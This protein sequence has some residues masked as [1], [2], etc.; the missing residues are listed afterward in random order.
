MKSNKNR[1]QEH[2]EKELNKD[3]ENR[4]HN[5]I[6]ILE[7]TITFLQMQCILGFQVEVK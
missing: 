2:R 4:K 7:L 5:Q 1:S 3:H 6:H